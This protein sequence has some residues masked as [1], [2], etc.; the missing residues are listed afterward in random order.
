[1]NHLWHS[2]KLETAQLQVK[3]ALEANPDTDIYDSELV[4]AN[5]WWSPRMIAN[6]GISLQLSSDEKTPFRSRVPSQS[7][8][9][10]AKQLQRARLLKIHIGL[11]IHGTR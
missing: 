4:P 11:L 2:K 10:R 9:R 1:M 5:T 7:Q 6:S 3:E 8:F